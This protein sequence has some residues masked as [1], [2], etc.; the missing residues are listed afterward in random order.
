MTITIEK[1]EDLAK[2][3][4]VEEGYEFPDDVVSEVDIETLGSIDVSGSIR[5]CESLKA[6]L[7]IEACGYIGANGSI[8]AGEYIKAGGSIDSDMYIYAGG[9]IRS[10]MWITARGQIIA[11]GLI[12]ATTVQTSEYVLSCEFRIEAN[13][14]WTKT[15]P[16]GRSFWDEMQ[17]EIYLERPKTVL[18][19][20][21]HWILKGH[22][23]CFLNI[24]DFFQPPGQ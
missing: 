2:Y 20:G 24:K 19:D 12:A 9:F 16:F 22:M 15:L 21:W 5:R 10:G 18:M 13:E 11:G 17:P 23:E 8:E 7:Y 3:G 14:I 4:S 6:M 1:F